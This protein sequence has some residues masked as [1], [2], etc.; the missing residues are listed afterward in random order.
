M[1]VTIGLDHVGPGQISGSH[2][3]LGLTLATAAVTPG[4]VHRR[5]GHIKIAEHRHDLFPRRA[6]AAQVDLFAASLVN[7]QLTVGHRTRKQNTDEKK[8]SDFHYYLAAPLSFT[9]LSTT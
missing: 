7:S 4:A 3:T 2:A 6:L 5:P 8:N 1:R 9:T